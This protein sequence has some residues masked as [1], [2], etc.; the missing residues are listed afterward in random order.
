MPVDVRAFSGTV[1]ANYL[2]Q[3]RQTD[4][5]ASERPTPTVMQTLDDLLWSITIKART[6][7]KSRLSKM[8]PSL[9]RRLRAGGAAVHVSGEKMK[10]FLDAIYAL[11]IAAIRPEGGGRRRGCRCGGG[12]TR[13]RPPAATQVRATSTTCGRHRLRHVA[14]VPRV[15]RRVDPRAARMDQPD[16]RTVRLQARKGDGRRSRPRNLRGRW[17]GRASLV[18]E[19]VPLFERAVSR[20]LDF[21]NAR[22][23][24]DGT[25]PPAA[26]SGAAVADVAAA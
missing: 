13:R 19:P 5:A 1:W 10:Q 14:R 21:L 9:V 24:A 26:R 6:G 20:A 25:A 8:I 23:S 12:P 2:K 4:G 16:A 15:R 17:P 11:H 7:Q 3:V 18:A 22:K